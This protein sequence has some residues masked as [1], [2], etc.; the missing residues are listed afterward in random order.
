[1]MD[2]SNVQHFEAKMFERINHFLSQPKYDSQ[3]YLNFNLNV[4]KNQKD[5][6]GFL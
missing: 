5:F 3:K 2:Q 1:M 6:K 4:L